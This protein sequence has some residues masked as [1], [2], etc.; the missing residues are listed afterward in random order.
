[1]FKASSEGSTVLT[2]LAFEFPQDPAT[3]PIQTQFMWGS[4]VMVAPVLDQG[5]TQVQ[6]YF[7]KNTKW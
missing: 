3:H 2:S 5:A 4:S 1:M 6:V 7:P